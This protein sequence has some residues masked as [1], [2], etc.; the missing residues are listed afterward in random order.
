MRVA[1]FNMISGDEVKKLAKIA[2]LKLSD[3]ELEAIRSDL[4]SVLKAFE[5]IQKVDVTG[6]EPSWHPVKLRGRVRKDEMEKGLTQ[7]QA[8]SNTKNKERGYFKGPRSL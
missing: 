8:L 1:L 5:K 4:D 7:E 3:R 6:V 2:R